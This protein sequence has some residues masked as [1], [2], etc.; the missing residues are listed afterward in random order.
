MERLISTIC[1]SENLKGRDTLEDFV[2]DRIILKWV[3]SKCC[4]I[5]VSQDVGGW[6]AFVYTVSNLPAL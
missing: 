4:R 1:K 5:H 3:L 2:L 6:R